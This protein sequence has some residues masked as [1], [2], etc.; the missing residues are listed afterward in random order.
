M[1]KVETSLP[2]EVYEDEMVPPGTIY[3]MDSVAVFGDDVPPNFP[4]S[5]FFL[6]NAENKDWI[7]KAESVFKMMED[8]SESFSRLD[9]LLKT[10]PDEL[11][12]QSKLKD[13][14]S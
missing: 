6:V 7:E 13:L 12:E 4:P 1:K 5:V 10:P 11:R 9:S 3:R 8:M 2:I 14:D